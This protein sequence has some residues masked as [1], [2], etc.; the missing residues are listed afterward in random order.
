MKYVTITKGWPLL[1]FLLTPPVTMAEELS[2]GMM[3]SNSC[4]GCHGPGGHSPGAIPSIADKSSDFIEKS[5]LEFRDGKRPATVMPRHAKGY[6]NE[7]IRLIADY[8]G[9]L[10]Q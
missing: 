1:L 5:L 8:F 2:R 6:T 9:K 10:K 3:L 4:M 7:E